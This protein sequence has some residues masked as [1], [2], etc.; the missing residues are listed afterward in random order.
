MKTLGLGTLL[1]NILLFLAGCTTG[2]V[3][4]PL[5]NPEPAAAA[6]DPNGPHLVDTSARYL[7]FPAVFPKAWAVKAPE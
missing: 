3:V 7:A 6:S 4:V 2:T 1:L 5:S